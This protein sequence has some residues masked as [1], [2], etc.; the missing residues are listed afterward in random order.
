MQADTFWRQADWPEINFTFKIDR[1]L[2][3]YQSQICNPKFWNTHTE[4]IQ[5]KAQDQIINFK[6]MFKRVP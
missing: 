5:G 1:F 4:I 2:Q 6:T 3:T